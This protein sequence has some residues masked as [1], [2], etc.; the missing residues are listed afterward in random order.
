VCGACLGTHAL[1]G[2]LKIDIA[3][4]FGLQ[5]C[6]LFYLVMLHL[7]LQLILFWIIFFS[8]VNNSN[9]YLCCSLI[10]NKWFQ[11]FP[12]TKFNNEDSTWIVTMFGIMFLNPLIEE[13]ECLI[14]TFEKK[15][16]I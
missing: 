14:D 3:I 9:Q 7:C 13:V 10:R 16:T 15:S 8:I 11:K 5:W 12:S 2:D 6:I 4:L 1:W